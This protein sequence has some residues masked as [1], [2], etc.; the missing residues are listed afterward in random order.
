M[1]CCWLVWCTCLARDRLMF[2]LCYPLSS[3]L[4][5]RSWFNL[6]ANKCSTDTV[7][8]YF[9]IILL[10]I[11]LTLFLLIPFLPPLVLFS[12]GS[13]NISRS[14][15]LYRLNSSLTISCLLSTFSASLISYKRVDVI[16]CDNYIYKPDWASTREKRDLPPACSLRN[17]SKNWS[18]MATAFL[19]V[20]LICLSMAGWW[21]MGW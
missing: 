1:E 20:F 12:P 2:L 3:C 14:C 8:S 10:Q 21:R 13:S 7:P 4:V 15:K 18:A 19:S 9:S 6:L 5:A 17:R 16:L 11:F